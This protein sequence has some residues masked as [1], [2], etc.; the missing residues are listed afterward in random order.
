VIPGVSHAPSVPNFWT[1][2]IRTDDVRNSSLTKFC[3]LTTSPALTKI[4]VTWIILTRDMFAV[5]NLFVE[6]VQLFIIDSECAE[7][8]PV[9]R[10]ISSLFGLKSCTALKCRLRRN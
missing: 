7:R 6:V 5:A 1:S 8:S 10:T 4:F 2:Y 9:E 3:M